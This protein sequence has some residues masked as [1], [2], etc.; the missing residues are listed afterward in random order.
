MYSNFQQRPTDPSVNQFE[1]VV[2]PSTLGK[3]FLIG[4]NDLLNSPLEKSKQTAKSRLYDSANNNLLKA[5]INKY[6]Q[7]VVEN[8]DQQFPPPPPVPHQDQP[9]QHNFSSNQQTAST[10]IIQDYQEPIKSSLK[11]SQ[12]NVLND[13]KASLTSSF[14]FNIEDE[15]KRKVI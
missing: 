10:S 5:S 11:P 6:K 4:K 15:F 7:N 13:T 3:S 12:S 1:R 2:R 14:T 9:H 8:D